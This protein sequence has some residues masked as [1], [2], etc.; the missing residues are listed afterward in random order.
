M[1]AATV[2]SLTASPASCGSLVTRRSAG[3][4]GALVRGDELVVS[5]VALLTDEGFATLG[6]LPAVVARG[7]DLEQS[8]RASDLKVRAAW[9]S[10]QITL[11][12][13]LRSEVRCRF[14]QEGQVLALLGDLRA[15]TQQLGT[16]GD[17]QWLVAGG[18]KRLQPST[19]HAPK[20]S[21]S[22]RELTAPLP[23][24]TV[25]PVSMTR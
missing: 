2:F 12:W 23:R 24:R 15:Q 1:R 5:S 22:S 21:T 16:L 25:L 18:L 9:P 8:G 11:L 17:I 14:S 13:W 7:R 3:N 6:L 19:L 10:T 4:P 20:R